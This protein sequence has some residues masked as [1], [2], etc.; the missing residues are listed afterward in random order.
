MME[1]CL[2]GVDGRAVIEALGSRAKD[3]ETVRTREIVTVL[4]VERYEL[5]VTDI[6]AALGARYDT[7][8]LWGRRGAKRRAADPG[9]RSEVDRADEHLARSGEGSDS[10]HRSGGTSTRI[11]DGSR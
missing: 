5:R 7:V 8:S 1:Q 4:G 11:R 6:A 2:E 3:E 10:A 9:F